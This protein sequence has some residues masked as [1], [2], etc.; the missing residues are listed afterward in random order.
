[1]FPPPDKHPFLAPRGPPTPSNARAWILSVLASSPSHTAT[2][3]RE[4]LP[5]HR[6]TRPTKGLPGSSQAGAA[7]LQDVAPLVSTADALTFMTY[8]FA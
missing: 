5:S 4:G 1:M 7:V 3:R 2:S 8:D 6:P